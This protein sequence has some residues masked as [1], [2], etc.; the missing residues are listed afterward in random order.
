V[1]SYGD[2]GVEPGGGQDDASARPEQEDAMTGTRVSVT[3]DD[4]HR[5]SL[6][7]VVDA[8]RGCGMEV[9]A[10]LEGLGMVTGFAPD[11]EAL[12]QLEGVAAVDA[13]LEYHLPPPDEEIQ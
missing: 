12:R 3:V 10:V 7:E 4:Q 8:L 9:D 6:H 5:A 13:E 2:G 11:A 1:T